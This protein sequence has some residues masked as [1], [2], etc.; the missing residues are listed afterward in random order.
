[1][2]FS[3]TASFT[4]GVT[5]FAIG[6]FTLRNTTSKSEL[7]LAMIPLLFG[8]QQIIEGVILLTFSHDGL[9]LRGRM[10]YAY[11]GF[12]HV[13][14]PIYLPFAIGLLEKSPLRRRIL[15]IFQAAGIAVGGYL[16]YSISMRPVVAEVIGKHIN[17]VSP[18]F[19]QMEMM[20]VYVAATCVSCLFSS[21]R[22]V[23]LF[24][25]LMFLAFLAAYQVYVGAFFSIW[26]FFAAI[27][28]LLIYVHLR[29]RQLGGFPGKISL[30]GRNGV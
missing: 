25:A 19:Y 2:C 15:Y 1:M 8:I 7:P 11:T 30:H 24:G 5:L 18:H 29:F 4:A 21:H 12:S 9:Q 20:V 16:F 22:F 23:N 27:L 17:Y 10:T 3:A 28:S 13:L 14:W 6:V 26:C